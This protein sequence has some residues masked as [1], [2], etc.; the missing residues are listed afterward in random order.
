MGPGKVCGERRSIDAFSEITPFRCRGRFSRE[1]ENRGIYI[2]I[3]VGPGT[4]DL[5]TCIFNG[6]TDKEWIVKSQFDKK[7]KHN[8]ATT[9]RYIYVFISVEINI[10]HVRE[11][12][13]N[14]TI[15]VAPY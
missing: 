3:L 15:S 2:I 8:N 12:K 4:V 9:S 7:K 6:T 1:R 11:E 10:K 14:K 13:A 5:M